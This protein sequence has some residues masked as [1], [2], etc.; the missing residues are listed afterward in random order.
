MFQKYQNM[1]LENFLDEKVFFLRVAIVLTCFQSEKSQ[2]KLDLMP[3]FL[4]KR[5]TKLV[6][7]K[8]K[9]RFRPILADSLKLKLYWVIEGQGFLFS[10]IYNLMGCFITATLIKSI[11]VNNVI[12]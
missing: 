1:V 11:K 7:I 3:S 6:K 10:L 12:R 5:F 2:N 4:L 9:G 8:G